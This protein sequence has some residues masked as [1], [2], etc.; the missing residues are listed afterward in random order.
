VIG[1]GP[2]WVFILAAYL[3]TALG[4]ALLIAFV[5][6]GSRRVEARIEKLEAESRPRVVREGER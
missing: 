4:V 1:L 5:V 6:A 3:G 2:H